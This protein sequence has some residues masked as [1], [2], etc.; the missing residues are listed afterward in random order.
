MVKKITLLASEGSLTFI[1][2]PNGWC[3]LSLTKNKKETRLGADL[4]A[5]LKNRLFHVITYKSELAMTDDI[6]GC[7]VTWVLNLSEEHASVYAH[8]NDN[9]LLF[10]FQDLN[11]HVIDTL[12]ITYDECDQWLK[13]LSTYKGGRYE[14]P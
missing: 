4:F 5:N 9:G 10:Y 8:R 6:D 7:A 1:I 14:Q 13:S 2:E 3:R 11:A 12:F